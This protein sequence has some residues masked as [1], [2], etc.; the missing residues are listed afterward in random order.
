[1]PQY[2]LTRD[3]DAPLSFTGEQIA[4]ATTRE[5][6]GDGQNRWHEVAVYQTAGGKYII[7]IQFCTQWQG[8]SG[9]REAHVES[10]LAGVAECLKS[11]III[12]TGIGYPPMPQYAEK[13]ARAEASLRRRWDALVGEI[14]AEIGAEEKIE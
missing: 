11:T 6:Q 12:P 10:D 3:G 4:T 13:Q 14:L 5:Q 8:E 9:T 2:K 1:M 7:E